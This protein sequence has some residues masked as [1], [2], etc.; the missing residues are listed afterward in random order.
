MRSHMLLLA[1]ALFGPLACA[2]DTADI[3]EK[4]VAAD[5]PETFAQQSA[6][7]EQEMQPD[8]RYEF[9]KPADKQRVKV[10]LAQMSSLLERSGSV[11]AMDNSTRIVLFNDQEEVNGL[12]KRN[13]ANRLVCES[14]QPI[15]SHIPVTHCHTY[16]QVEETARNT[17]IGMQ[18]FDLSRVCNGPGG[19]ESNACAP[20]SHQRTAG[21]H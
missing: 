19:G 7:I 18:Q 12:L 11:A 16:R 1:A 8:G 20:G 15:G 10:L 17:K 13:D 4:P 5:T 21:G 9:T 14:R 2:A 6:W 3:I